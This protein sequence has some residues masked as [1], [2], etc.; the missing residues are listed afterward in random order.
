M[1]KR[2]LFRNVQIQRYC[3]PF[4]RLTVSGR[5]TT[6]RATVS[7]RIENFVRKEWIRNAETTKRQE[8]SG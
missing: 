7:W 1:E 5:K 4:K 6:S 3:G 2:S 8:E